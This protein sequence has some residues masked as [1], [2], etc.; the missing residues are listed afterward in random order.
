MYSSIGRA[1]DCDSKGCRFKSY[2]T[3][4]YKLAINKKIYK[5]TLQNLPNYKPT[6]LWW[7]IKK[8]KL[9]AWD[10]FTQ[11]KIQIKYAY[12]ILDKPKKQFISSVKINNLYTYTTGLVLKA[13][14]QNSRSLRRSKLGFNILF[15]FISKKLQLSQKL[16]QLIC[17][18]KTLNHYSIVK[19][20]LSSYFSLWGVKN[21]I[22]IKIKK[23]YTQHNYKKIS[24]INKRMRK[25]YIVE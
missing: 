23:N 18:V 19:S 10:L 1:L 3:P 12:L 15:N 6:L 16:L 24:Y 11:S 2:Y 4:L 8:K 9:K 25:K 22:L 13:I 14:S 21:T 17:L 7:K 5:I 20:N